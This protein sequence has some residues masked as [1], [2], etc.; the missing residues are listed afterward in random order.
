ME[1]LREAKINKICKICNRKSK[2]LL[3]VE[4]INYEG[5]NFYMRLDLNDKLNV[6]KL[7]W[8]DLDI[9]PLKDID[10]FLNVELVPYTF[11]QDIMHILNTDRITDYNVDNTDESDLVIVIFYGKDKV[12]QMRFNKYIPKNLIYLQPIFMH[13]FMNLPK[14]LEEYYD[15][16]LS[17][18]TGTS[19]KYELKKEKKFD[20]LNGD[21]KTF[22]SDDIIK[23]AEDYLEQNRVMFLDRMHNWYFGV[24]K[25]N[26]S[27]V[28]I[29]STS[30]EK[31]TVTLSCNCHANHYCEHICAI[32][33]AIRK[34]VY[35]PFFKV[36]KNKKISSAIDH[37]TNAECYLCLG[38]KGKNGIILIKE[39]R[40]IVVPLTDKNGELLWKIVDDVDGQLQKQ[41]EERLNQN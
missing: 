26:V 22:F 4:F 16:L 32:I 37:L 24:V 29:I 39:N 31:G 21:L 14:K 13:L 5:H 28:V 2:I 40:L 38:L 7:T 33:M 36:I 15:E 34:D 17:E 20:L 27:S 30:R 9:I 18:L 35:K 8:C 23:K 19:F 11:Y 3:E 25:S 10:Q 1:N 6:C 41:I 12:K